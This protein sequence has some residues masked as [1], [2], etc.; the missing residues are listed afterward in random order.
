MGGAPGNRLPVSCPMRPP[1]RLSAS[2]PPCHASPS[3]T[4]RPASARGPC[5]P[6][7]ELPCD[8]CRDPEATRRCLAQRE[9]RTRAAVRQ[10]VQQERRAD[11]GSGGEEEGSGDGGG[12]NGSDEE[13]KEKGGGGADRRQ[14][15]CCWGSAIQLEAGKTGAAGA[16]QQT[17]D[18]PMEL[19][20]TEEQQGN[21]Q[22]PAPPQL[23]QC[24]HPQPQ[25][26][27]Q[28]RCQQHLPLA[29]LSSQGPRL[30]FKRPA[31]VKRPAATVA[32]AATMNT[33]PTAAAEGRGGGQ[34]S[35]AGSTAASEQWRRQDAESQAAATASAA[36]TATVAATHLTAAAE[37][38]Q[39]RRPRVAPYL[40]RPRACSASAVH[41]YRGSCG[42][43]AGA[44]APDEGAAAAAGA[45]V[46]AP[47]AAAG[48]LE[49]PGQGHASMG[50][51][52]DGG[53][54]PLEGQQ[55]PRPPLL[56]GGPHFAGARRSFK[57]PL[58]SRR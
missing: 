15:R 20:C 36:V 14:R 31:L 30:A 57:P 8:V 3:M 47:A 45:P 37:L 6:A 22:Q 55:R 48:V 16:V 28:R 54:Q 5:S 4:P 23:Q 19:H 52:A 29:G 17:K 7:T 27:P 13:F 2:A 34:G 58:L 39:A 25:P 49:R 35:A 38:Q 50:D 42:S 32:G 44:A 24:R 26:L 53:V 51:C 21:K 41:A 10:R 46:P 1:T 11:N 43:S 9:E 40:K 12:S 56:R 18:A 33:R